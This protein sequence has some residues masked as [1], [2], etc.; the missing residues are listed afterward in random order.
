[1][2]GSA[3]LPECTTLRLRRERGVLH[4]MLHR[5]EVRN[6]MSLRMVE[7]VRAAFR[8]VREDR[9]VRAVVLRGAAGHFCAGADLKELAEG[10]E[11]GG[12][13]EYS[14]AFGRMLADV[15]AAPQVVIAL[16]EGAVLGGGFGLACAADVAIADAGARF[17]MPETTRGIPPAQIAPFV[18]R[19]VGLAQ[20]RRLAL[21]GLRFDA[22]EAQRLGV[23]HQVVAGGAALEAAA[24]AALA[25]VRQCAPG[26]NAVT[27]AL[28]LEAAAAVREAPAALVERAAQDFADAVV[29]PEGREGT[30]AFV[31]KR[32][33]GWAR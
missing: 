29:G 19:R 31:E 5:P 25:N 28:L 17:G 7:E 33:P 32:P 22:G 23:A 12:W 8:A 4:L 21:L 27:K 2:T 6:A 9:G 24:E 15:E 11:R 18:V 14:R 3:A 16:L 13:L 20:A 10:K 26:A 1:M 30:A